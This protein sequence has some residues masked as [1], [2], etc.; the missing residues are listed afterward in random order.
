[1][2]QRVFSADRGADRDAD[3]DADRTAPQGRRS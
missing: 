3:R 1:M 2:L